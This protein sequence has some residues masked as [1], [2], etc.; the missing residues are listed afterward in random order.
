MGRPAGYAGTL[1]KTTQGAHLPTTLACET[2]HKTGARA[3]SSSQ[4]QDV[5]LLPKIAE[6]GACHGKTREQTATAAGS[7]CAEC[8]GFHSP[9]QATAPRKQELARGALI[10]VQ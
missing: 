8:H 3:K 9:G 5:M 6:C 2:C 1:Q 4:D 7:D 10:Q